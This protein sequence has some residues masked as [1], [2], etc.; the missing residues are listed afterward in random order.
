[1]ALTRVQEL[2]TKVDDDRATLEWLDGDEQLQHSM[3]HD[4]GGL[5][6]CHNR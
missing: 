3:V 2:T 5:E 4:D 1:M 6:V